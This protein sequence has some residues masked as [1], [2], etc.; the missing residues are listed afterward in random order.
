MVDND[1]L[2]K[3]S[4]NP[5]SVAEFYFTKRTVPTLRYMYTPTCCT[6][7]YHEPGSRDKS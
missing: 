6:S 7:V 3:V 1:S 4:I 5:R 2:L